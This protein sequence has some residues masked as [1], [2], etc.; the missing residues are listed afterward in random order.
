M[1]L[2]GEAAHVVR[3]GQHCG[4]APTVVEEAA[5]PVGVGDQHGLGGQG[6]GGLNDALILRAGTSGVVTDV[7]HVDVPA[8]PPGLGHARTTEDLAVLDVGVEEVPPVVGAGAAGHRARR[9]SGHV[10]GVVAELVVVVLGVH[11]DRE[12]H[13]LDVAQA[14]GLARFLTRA[15]E[16]GEQ[17]GRQ[18]RDDRDDDQQLDE[19]EALA[20]HVFT[21]FH[22]VCQE[23]TL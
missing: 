11:H 3:A 4:V 15:G 22:I 9:A 6:D 20:S 7:A 12:T 13:L 1:A 21:S 17:D 23:A 18:D 2:R 5:G 10:G 8:V 14:G 16:D 19:R